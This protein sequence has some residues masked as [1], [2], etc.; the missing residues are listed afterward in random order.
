[1][2]SPT[3]IAKQARKSD[4]TLSRHRQRLETLTAL[5]HTWQTLSNGLYAPEHRYIKK[6][7]NRIQIEKRLISTSNVP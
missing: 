5:L 3:A 4:E 6:L 2:R 1:M 7:R